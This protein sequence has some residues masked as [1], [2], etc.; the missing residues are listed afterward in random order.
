VKTDK[1]QCEGA[2]APIFSADRSRFIGLR[3]V[4]DMNKLALIARLETTYGSGV[5]GFARDERF[6][7]GEATVGKELDSP[8]I[9]V[10]DATTGRV[11][12]HRKPIETLRELEQVAWSFFDDADAKMYLV[13]F[14]IDPEHGVQRLVF[15][16]QC[17]AGP[18][19]LPQG[20]ARPAGIPTRHCPELGPAFDE[21]VVRRGHSPRVE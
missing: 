9:V 6:V 3:A 18:V 2:L 14:V 15:D 16:D 8:S 17:W 20:K 7:I 19:R 12:R 10:W 4:W 11:A 5:W 21:M 1:S 13:G